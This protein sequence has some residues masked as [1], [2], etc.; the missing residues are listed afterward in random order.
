MSVMYNV[1]LAL[2]TFINTFPFFTIHDLGCITYDRVG[3]GLFA[4]ATFDL[5]GEFA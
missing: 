4:D 1:Q 3:E 2:A 5:E